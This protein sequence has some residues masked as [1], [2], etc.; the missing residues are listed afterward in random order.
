M[1]ERELVEPDRL[2]DALALELIKYW[3]LVV[4]KALTVLKVFI[5]N[6]NKH[7]NNKSISIALRLSKFRGQV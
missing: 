3:E 5:I 4:P 6:C 7:L 1:I 2:I